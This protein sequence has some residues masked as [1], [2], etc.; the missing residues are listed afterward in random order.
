MYKYAIG[1]PTN[2]KEHFAI[3][4]PLADKG[5]LDAM[6]DLGVMYANGF[7]DDRRDTDWVKWLYDPAYEGHS[8]AQYNLGLVNIDCRW[9]FPPELE[10]NPKKCFLKAAVKKLAEAQLVMGILYDRGLGVFKDHE[11]AIYWY[12][13]AVKQGLALAELYLGQVY[14][15][16]MRWHLARKWFKS[17]ADKGIASAQNNLA[18]LYYFGRGVKKN[19]KKAVKLLELASK[20]ELP[21]AKINL[22]LIYI[23][24]KEMG[25]DSQQALNLV[26]SVQNREE[27]R[28]I[29][30]FG[31]GMICEIGLEGDPDYERAADHYCRAFTSCDRTGWQ[32]IRSDCR[33]GLFHDVARFFMIRLKS[34]L[35]DQSEDCELRR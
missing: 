12:E 7:G 24:E 26:L 2:L 31:L 18:E 23:Q 17:A 33:F 32:A 13:M 11:S 9:G 8:I 28:H 1:E 21:M 4:K 35:R 20:Q 34:K 27:V 22:G 19:V 25:V 14:M 16:M 6:N 29:V 5:N 3:C 30:E 10:E 15:E